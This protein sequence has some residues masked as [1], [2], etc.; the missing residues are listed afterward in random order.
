MSKSWKP[1]SHEG[2][3]KMLRKFTS[4]F[5][6]ELR[7]R[8]GFAAATPLGKWVDDVLYPL[9]ARVLTCFPSWEDETKRTKHETVALARAEEEVMLPYTLMVEMTRWNPLLTAEDLSDLGVPPRPSGSRQSSPVETNYP[10]CEV[11]TSLIAH[12]IFHFFPR[13]EK[14]EKPRKGKPAGQHGGELK[15]VVSDVE[16]TRYED[17][18]HS[19]FST[20]SPI[21]ILFDGS[22][23]GK[24]VYFAIRWENNVGKKGPFGPILSAI[25][26]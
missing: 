15:Y 24:K 2:I 1:T 8:A 20:T 4:N 10:D 3:V 22:L 16:I 11:D 7:S 6:P 25:I 12:L 23:R 13:E 18:V 14:G 5:S 21:T 17:L 9:I 19:E 26:P